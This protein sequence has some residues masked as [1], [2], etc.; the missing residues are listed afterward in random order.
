MQLVLASANQG[1]LREMRAL[2]E[3]LGIEINSAAEL[4][5]TEEVPET[6]STFY[7]NAFIK[8]KAVC[9]ALGVPA[10]ADDSGLAVDALDGAPGVFSA[11][12]SGQDANPARNNAKLLAEMQGVPEDK[13]GGA[14]VC[15]M[16]CYKPDGTSLASQAEL[17]GRIGF[18]LVG[19]GGFGYDPLFY[20][21]GKG[22]TAAQLE[23][24]EKNAI[25]HRGQAIQ[26]LMVDLEVFL[27]LKP[28]PACSG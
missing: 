1:K 25:S 10:L 8:A 17:R 13:R 12:Y 26:K 23:P 19:D 22:R 3:P 14:F 24:Q 21:P 20:I 18:K 9:E 5:F 2:L 16:C 6:G 4:G 11:R 28:P 15:A 7:E 27:G